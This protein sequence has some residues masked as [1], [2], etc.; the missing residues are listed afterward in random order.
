MPANRI[1]IAIDGPAGSGK[2]TTAR[3]VAE[4][5]HF[6]YID[7]GAFYRA[8]TL[9]VIRHRINL[10]DRIKLEKMLQETNI[11]LENAANGLTVF[12]NEEDVTQKIRSTEV[13]GLVSQVSEHELVRQEVTKQLR[14]ISRHHSVVLDGRDIGTVVFPDAQV[15]IY[16]E[17]SITER[18]KRRLQELTANGA[19]L[20][21]TAIEKDIVRRD[22]I[23]SQRKIAPLKKAEDAI[24]LETTD[25]SVEEGVDFIVNKAREIMNH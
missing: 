5:L 13:T 19:T 3:L 7:S 4:K 16:L 12:L 9:Q 11:R 21:S 6:L 24:V 1:V 18:A 17:A 2:S 20:S 8:V 15:K 10:D 14:D 23:D 22:K 25:L